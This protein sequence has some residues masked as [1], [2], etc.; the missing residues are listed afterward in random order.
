MKRAIAA[1]AITLAVAGSAMAKSESQQHCY[2][3]DGYHVCEFQPSGRVNVSWG[4]EDDYHS[5]WYTAKTWPAAHA[6][7]KKIWERD[8]ADVQA[9][10]C[11]L[12][13]ATHYDFDGCPPSPAKDTME[14]CLK[15]YKKQPWSAPGIAKN[16]QAQCTEEIRKA[17]E[18]DK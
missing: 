10:G 16:A 2:G 3:R 18:A 6:Q 11:S 4:D 5:L 12:Q 1:I 14:E 8:D 13:R 7:F 15:N 9:Y 17:E